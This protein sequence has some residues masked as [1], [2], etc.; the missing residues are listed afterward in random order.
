MGS[1]QDVHL[2][3]Q[4][5]AHGLND[6]MLHMCSRSLGLLQHWRTLCSSLTATTF[7]FFSLA[8]SLIPEQLIYFP[9]KIVCALLCH[10]VRTY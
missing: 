4:H 1:G 3:P 10:W 9:K 7:S 2:A 5:Y 6:G 8:A